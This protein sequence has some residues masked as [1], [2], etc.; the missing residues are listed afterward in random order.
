M[1]PTTSL[2][3]DTPHEDSS[4]TPHTNYVFIKNLSFTFLRLPF[5]WNA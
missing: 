5:A 3:Q 4:E 2:Q 1:D